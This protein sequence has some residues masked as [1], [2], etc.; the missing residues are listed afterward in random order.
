MV[1]QATH[2]KKSLKPFQI[3]GAAFLH[4]RPHA[5]LADE[6]GLGKTVQAIYAANALDLQRI[7]VVCPASVR[8]GWRQELD[9]CGATGAWD[10]I[11]YEQAVRGYANVGYYDGLI[12]D[13]AHYLKTPESQR[14]Q[15]VFGKSG[16]ARHPKIRARWALTGTPVLNRPRELWPILKCLHAG[17][18]G[19]SWD[20]FSKRYC[21]A[22]YN[23]REMDTRGATNLDELARRLEGF[24]MRRAKADVLPEL[25]AKIVTRVA[26]PFDEGLLREAES[27]IL[28]REAKLSAAAEDYSALGDLAVMLHQTGL[29]KV[30]GVVA[31]VKELLETEEKVVIF[32]KHTDVG[33]A[34]FM[35]FECATVVYQGGMSDAAK[36]AAIQGF[37]SFGKSVFLAQ[38]QAAGTGINGLQEVCSTV[39]FAELDWTPGTMSQAIDRLHRMGQKAGSVNACLTHAPGSME[40]A[41][42]GVQNHKGSVVGRLMGESGWKA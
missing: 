22:F 11:S 21:G 8:S 18:A 30:K 7:L 17:F 10:I 27:K 24:M 29:A 41:V 33:A 19:E 35:A 4:Q 5:L 23:G 39:V 14:T 25:P 3:L 28:D 32:F 15:A 37:Q 36:V 40:S 13:E 9:E 1:L 26:V 34:L 31:F 20:N 38:I 2:F 6:P 16:M 42:L 12:L